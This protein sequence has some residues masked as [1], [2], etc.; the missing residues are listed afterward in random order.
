MVVDADAVVFLP[1]AALEIPVAVVTGRLV[2]G[3]EGFGQAEI[4]D[5]LKGGAA[6]RQ[7]QGVG[8]PVLG[9]GGILGLGDDVVVAAEDERLLGL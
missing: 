8:Q 2:A 4:G 3:A 6:L 1:R 7:E 9:V 5:A